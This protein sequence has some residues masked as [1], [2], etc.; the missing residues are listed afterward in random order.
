MRC[1]VVGHPVAHSLSPVIHQAAYRALGLDWSYDAIDVE[2][3]GLRAF[4]DGLDESWRGLSVTMPHKLDLMELGE[5]DETVELLGA[6][7]T[8]VRRDGRVIV[9]NTDVTGAGVAL[10]SRGVGEVSKVVMLGAG[11]TARSVLAAA[12]DLGVDEV[13]IMSRAR[14]RS[15]EILE[16]ADRL[17]ARAAWLPFESEPPHCDLMVST[18]PAGSLMHRVEDLAART[19]AVFDVIYDPWPTPL[20]VAGEHEGV[21]VVDGLDLLVGQAVDQIRLMTG[22]EVAMDVLRSAAQNG[23]AGRARL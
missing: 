10:R 14:E 23:L 21:T 12:V 9:R 6:A 2:P 18:V 20:T 19:D 4:V 8:W 5:I 11:A 15:T 7:N 13:I 17:G 22:H 16:L 3:G 1:A